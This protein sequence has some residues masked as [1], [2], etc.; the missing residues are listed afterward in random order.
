MGGMFNSSTVS[1]DANNL[2]KGCGDDVYVAKLMSPSIG[3]NENYINN[4]LPVYP[5][6]SDGKFT[7]EGEGEIV[8]YNAL[9]E[10]MLTEKLNNKTSFR[11][12]NIYI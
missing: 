6:P 11:F 9:G 2:Y 10:V 5:N 12:T 4:Q 8:F 1:F 3:L 7:I